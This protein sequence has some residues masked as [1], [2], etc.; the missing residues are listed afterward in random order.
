LHF[1][2]AFGAA[3]VY[4]AASRKLRF[5]RERPVIAGLLYG[6]GVYVFMNYVVLPLSAFPKRARPPSGIALVNGILAVVLLVGLP[7]ALISRS[8]YQDVNGA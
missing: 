2:I 6:A 7:I 5:L 3:T 4:Y 8:K 1:I